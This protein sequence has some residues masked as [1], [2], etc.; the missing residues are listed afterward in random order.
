MDRP[1]PRQTAGEYMDSWMAETSRDCRRGGLVM[2]AVLAFVF[3]A[4]LAAGAVC[5]FRALR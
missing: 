3:S 1:D 5:L 2:A 4:A